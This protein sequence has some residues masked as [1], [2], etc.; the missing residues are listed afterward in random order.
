MMI[1]HAVEG[2][3]AAALNK[4]AVCLAWMGTRARLLG[5]YCRADTHNT[6]KREKV[7]EYV[8]VYNRCF[9]E[10]RK[11]SRGIQTKP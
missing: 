2:Y 9:Q 6:V 5:D 11:S 4:V 7:K 8:R 3:A 1:P 10:N